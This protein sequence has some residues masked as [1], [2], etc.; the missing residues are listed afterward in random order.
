MAIGQVNIDFKIMQTAMREHV[1][2]KAKQYGSTIVYEVD[3]QLIE[4]DPCNSK[5]II[6]RNK[7]NTK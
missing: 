5:K 6:L 7:A 2:N 4:E 3:G 1:R